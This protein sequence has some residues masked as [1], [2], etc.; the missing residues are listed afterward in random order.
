[1][2][3]AGCFLRWIELV[4]ADVCAGCCQH[5]KMDADK[6]QMQVGAAILRIRSRLQLSQSTLAE[7]ANLC[8]TY[9]TGLEA[10]KRNPSIKTLRTLAKA[11]DID[12]AELFGSEEK[13]G[14]RRRRLPLGPRIRKLREERGLSQAAL[15]AVLQIDRTYVAGV[16]LGN[17]NPTLR[18][19]ARIAQALN[20]SV[21]ALLSATQNGDQ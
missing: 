18:S 17:R 13:N 10:G 8:C 1:M 9:L 20:I 14:A 6:L 2:T 3:L 4:M 16:E 5:P 7:R 15:A 21:T 19:V 11:L 12:I